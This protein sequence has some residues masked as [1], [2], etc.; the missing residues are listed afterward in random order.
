MDSVGNFSATYI[1][2]LWIAGYF[3]RGLKITRNP[4]VWQSAYSGS[5]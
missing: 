4:E 3:I 5:V 1:Q 2:E